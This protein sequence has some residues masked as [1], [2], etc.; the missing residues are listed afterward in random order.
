MAGFEFDDV[1]ARHRA[2]VVE[3]VTIPVARL[4]DIVASKAAAGREKDRLFLAVH[5]EALG[6]LIA[7]D[8]E[9]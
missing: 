9:S 1:F 5:A 6:S 2:F 4:R 3:G 8:H 7:K